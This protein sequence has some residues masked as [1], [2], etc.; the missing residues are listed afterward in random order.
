MACGAVLV[1]AG[2]SQRMGFNKTTASLAGQMV[3]LWSLGVIDAVQ[4]IS[5]IV[6]VCSEENREPIRD[7]LRERTFRSP[8]DLCLG[9]ETRADSVRNGIAALATDVDLV[10]IHDAARPLVT[11]ELLRAGIERARTCGAAVAAIPVTDTIKCVDDD[12]VEAT[13]ERSRLVAA[14]TPQIFCRAWLDA[15]YRR[16]DQSGRAETFT[17]EAGLLEWA[18]YQVHVFPGCVENLK[19]TTPF[20]LAVAEL[21]L[22]QRNRPAS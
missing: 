2:R 19:L 1:A 16:L 17:D 22:A 3:L 4:P 6:V 15:A 13:V 9:G 18:G 10:L 20:D 14:Q 12:V 7:T 8:V 5:G 21:I 11:P